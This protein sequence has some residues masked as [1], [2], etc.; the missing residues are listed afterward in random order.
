MVLPLLYTIA[1]QG[2]YLALRLAAPFH[3]KANQFI[4]GRKQ[5]PFDLEKIKKQNKPVVW[6]HCASVGEFEQ[7]LPLIDAVHNDFPGYQCLVSFFSPSGYQFAQKRYPELL[8]TYLPFDTPANCEY[9]IRKVRPHIAIFIK[10]ELW[11]NILNTCRKA[12]IPLFLV[13]A[14]FRENQIYFSRLAPLLNPLFRPFTHFFLQ[15]ETSAQLL[16][17]VGFSNYSVV[18][19]TRFDRVIAVSLSPLNDNILNRFCPE[20]RTAFVAGSVWDSDIPVLNEIISA[21]PKNMP[22]ILAPHQPGHFNTHWIN[23]PFITFTQFDRYK[24][25]RILIL[26]TLGLLSAT[27]RL[28]RIAYVGGGFGKGIHNVLEAGVYGNPVLIGPNYKKFREA[29]EMVNRNVAFPVTPENTVQK[30]QFI[31]ENIEALRPTLTH[32]F[33]SRTNATEKIMVFLRKAEFLSAKP[34]FKN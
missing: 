16:S 15:N 3:T 14:H 10:Y 13:D 19:D 28:A 11:Y 29:L 12:E 8:I 23:E 24:N 4:Q 25:E 30:I 17:G 2:Y 33:N 18:G 26:D 9:F 21:L 31:L 7:A 34:F 1:M 27:Y 22:I 32:Y 20:H 6:F 5:I